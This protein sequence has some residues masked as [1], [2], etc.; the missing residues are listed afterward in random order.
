MP[1]QWV[2][3]LGFD[4]VTIAVADLHAIERIVCGEANARVLA[5]G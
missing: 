2:A 1:W 3:E 5:R 4:H